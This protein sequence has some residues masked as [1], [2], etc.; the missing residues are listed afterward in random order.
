MRRTGRM[1]SVQKKIV[2]LL[3][4]LAMIVAGVLLG[5]ILITLAYCIPVNQT[6]AQKSIDSLEGEGWYPS[7]TQLKSSLDTYFHSY[8][9]GVLDGATDGL[10][11]EKAT[12]QIEGNPL[13]EA[14]NM[15]GYTY[16]WHGYVVIL[17][18]L[19][20]FMDYEQFRFLNCILQLLMMFFVAH[21]IWEKKGQ[22]YALAL[23][24]SYFLMM[25]MAMFLS[26]QFSWIFYIAMALSLL[27]CYRH[28]WFTEKRIPYIFVI[29]GMLTSFL[30]LLTYP[31]YTWAFPLLLL[32]LL[33]EDGQ[34]ALNYVKTV[35]VSGLGWILGYAGMWFGKWA[36]AGWIVHRNVIQEAWDEVMFRSGSDEALNL[37]DRLVALYRNWKHYEYP[38][39][40]ALLAIWLTWF[41]Y[42]SLNG[43][44]QIVRQE[45]NGAYLLIT[46]SSFVWYFVLANHTLGHHFF[47]YRIWGVA[48]TGILFLF[49][50]SIAI[51]KDNCSGRDRIYTFCKW[52][53]LCIL[54][55][56]LTLTAREDVSVLNGN[57]EYQEIELPKGEQIEEEFL[58]SFPRVKNF[59]M[60]IRT[61]SVKGQCIIE[62]RDDEKTL[63]ELNWKLAELADTEYVQVP[64]DWNFKR[65]SN[66]RIVIHL[67]ENEGPVY[68]RFTKDNVNPMLELGVAKIGGDIISGQLTSGIVYSYRPLSK[69][70]LLFLTISWLGLL[71]ALSFEVEQIV[72]WVFHRLKGKSGSV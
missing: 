35:V 1:K 50:G 8:L 26:L 39:Y 4:V 72:M 53:I 52:G 51:C 12:R 56:M 67:E 2:G 31:L 54:A 57:V 59:A 42:K 34:K 3:K 5:A 13:W 64:V 28:T 16:Y 21:F 63:Y 30:D 69:Y 43:K 19:L 23:L 40:A 17:R 71:T 65:D 10:M 37:F 14:M 48:I 24:T 38:L 45:K 29:A 68:L 66:Y 55:V 18:V 32:I 36:L 20:L 22:R 61:E 47:T 62:I 6:N 11:L 33:S 27:I 15:E 7:A 9:P 49:C 41:I 44:T 58:P 70:T 25:P 46:L 60:G